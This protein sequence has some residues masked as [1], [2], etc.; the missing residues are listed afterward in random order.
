MCSLFFPAEDDTVSSSLFLRSILMCIFLRV[1][2]TQKRASRHQPD[3]SISL[4]NSMMMIS[5][6]Y[7]FVLLFKRREENKKQLVSSSKEEEN[8]KLSST[9]VVFKRTPGFGTNTEKRAMMTTTSSSCCSSGV[10]GVLS[11]TSSSSSLLKKMKENKTNVMSVRRRH[12]Q[13]PHHHHHHHASETKR[14]GRRAGAALSVAAVMMPSLLPSSHQH[15]HQSSSSSSSVVSLDNNNNTMKRGKVAA[16]AAAAARDYHRQQQQ[17]EEDTTISS[18]NS[19]TTRTIQERV[20]NEN[21]A[22]QKRRNKLLGLFGKGSMMFVLVAMMVTASALL[23]PETALAKSKAV[24][25]EQSSGFSVKVIL[26]WILHLDKHLVEL[27]ATSGK[28]AYGVLFGIIFAETGF[29]VT[30][31]LPGDSLLFACGAL[32][33]I[34]VLNFP[35]VY[36]LLF[37]AAVLG[38][39]VNYM[40]GSFFGE[41]AIRK[42]PRIFKPDYIAKTRTFYDKYGGRTVV[43]ARFFV[44]VRTF[45]PF[46]AGVAKMNYSK[47]ALY[48]VMGAGVWITSFMGLGYFFGNVPVVKE[49]FATT[50]VVIIL[51]SLLPIIVEIV[52]HKKDSSANSASA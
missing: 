45:A 21:N 12:H 13:R 18:V 48:N 34:G 4:F 44:I 31:F 38:D 25:A 42:N 26:D 11:S 14:D 29:V 47:F 7:S 30:P 19:T 2:C 36:G 1:L 10:F 27:F 35:L 33:A 6:V 51:L 24:I 46:I 32:G 3:F 8:N 39:T 28:M 20:L 15:Q 49:N 16:K 5:H 43:L 23:F 22:S 37:L 40:C 52:N 9:L 17:S 41:V 50:I